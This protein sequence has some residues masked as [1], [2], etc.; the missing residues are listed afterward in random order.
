MRAAA[1][2]S[3]MRA[4][5]YPRFSNTRRAARSSAALLRL[6]CLVNASKSRWAALAGGGAPLLLDTRPSLWCSERT[7]KNRISIQS[8]DETRA[9][10]DDGRHDDWGVSE[11][12]DRRG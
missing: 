2:M 7:F 3:P 8:C 9:I 6:P 11:P 5:W 1:V 12:T 4:S 10:L